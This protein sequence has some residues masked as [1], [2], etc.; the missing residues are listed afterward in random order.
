MSKASGTWN[1]HPDHT[2]S[3]VTRLH[4]HG[5]VAS[6]EEH[7]E[8]VSLYDIVHQLSRLIDALLS[9]ETQGALSR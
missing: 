4:F 8:M 3:E 2:P 6:Q 7:P 9:Q 5:P 1:P